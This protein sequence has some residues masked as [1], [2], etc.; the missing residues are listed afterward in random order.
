MEKSLTNTTLL[1]HFKSFLPWNTSY[2]IK[3][4]ITWLSISGLPSQ[5]WSSKPFTSIANLWGDVLIPEECNARQFNRSTGKVYV[6]TEH[7]NFI[8]DSFAVPIDNEIFTIR[9]TKIKEDIDSFFNGYMLD[10]S[11][12]DN[13][14]TLGDMFDSQNIGADDHATRKYGEDEEDSDEEN[15]G[16]DNNTSKDDEENVN[17]NSSDGIPFLDKPAGIKIPMHPLE[18]YYEDISTSA[19]PVVNDK[20]HMPD[21]PDYFGRTCSKSNSQGGIIAIWDT[22][23][24]SFISSMDGDG[25][26]AIFGKWLQIDTTCLMVVVYAP[27]DKNRKEKLRRDITNII[28]HFNILSIVMGDFNEV[29]TASERMGSIFDPFGASKF[30]NF[31]NMVGL[32]DIPLGGKRF[33]R[34]DNI[35]SKLSKI[36]RIMVSKYY[37][38]RWPNSYVLALPREFS[39]HSPLF[40][41]NLV[42]FTIPGS[43]MLN[44]SLCSILVG[45]LQATVQSRESSITVSLKNQLEVL[46]NKAES[47]PLSSNKATAQINIVRDLTAL[48]RSKILDLHQKAKIRWAMDGDENSRFFHGMINSNLNRIRING[49]NIIGSWITEPL[50]LDDSQLLDQPFTLQEIKITDVI[51]DDIAAYVQEFEA[52]SYIPRGCNSSFITLIPKIEDPLVIGDYRPISLIGLPIGAK[53][54]RCANW[55]ALIDKFQKRLSSW[56]SKSLSIGGRLT[57]IKSILGSLRVYYFSTF[58]APLE[59]I[60]K[61]KGLRRKFFWGG[62]MDDKKISWIAWNKVIALMSCGGLGIGDLKSSNL[63]MLCKCLPSTFKKKVGDGSRTKFWHD[64][65]L[66]GLNLKET[67]PKVFYLETHQSCLIKPIRSKEEFTEFASLCN[68]VSH[69]RLTSVEDKWECTTSDSRIFM[70]KGMRAHIT[71]MST[72]IF[73]S[74]NKILPLKINIFTWRTLNGRLPTRLNLDSRGIDLH[75]IRCPLCDDAIESEEHLFVY[76]KIAKKHGKVLGIGGKSQMST[77]QTFKKQLPLLKR[78]PLQQP[79]SNSLILWFNQLF[80]IYGD[81]GMTWFF[82]LVQM[83]YV[84]N[85]LQVSQFEVEHGPLLAKKPMIVESYNESIFPTLQMNV[86]A[87]MFSEGP[88]ATASWHRYVVAKHHSDDRTQHLAT[89]CVVAKS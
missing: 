54:S 15:C 86:I 84:S 88:T 29:R 7:L 31:I 39:Y 16:S 57:L 68:L 82:L 75:S 18:R 21:N 63:A 48:E 64:E 40:L 45:P 27:H 74:S 58:K 33:T 9:V 5:M 23:Y 17:I 35:G 89:T 41:S 22:S 14:T 85:S 59:V 28:N 20:Y 10:T 24:F 38:D 65:W 61:L 79:T 77:S 34:M 49:L 6:L 43:L 60:N 4:R 8:R 32:W 83:E 51:K 69:L 52:T 81:F 73:S 66:G 12:E 1:S 2:R 11:D 30:N 42:N 55:N 80:G 56:K 72:S 36:D 70:I 3:N 53:M 71:A 62:N 76:C 19:A 13:S 67:F 26:V 44:L 25:F 50:S 87:M 47:G 37:I 78:P 46:N